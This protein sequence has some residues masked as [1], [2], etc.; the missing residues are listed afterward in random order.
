MLNLS[1]Q[2]ML[3]NANALNPNLIH[4]T[5]SRTLTHKD[6]CYQHGLFY[7]L[8]Y[9]I[10]SCCSLGGSLPP[11]WNHP[12]PHTCMH[13]Q[14]SV[15]PGH[16]AEKIRASVWFIHI[17]SEYIYFSYH[18]GTYPLPTHTETPTHQHCRMHKDSP[19]GTACKIQCISLSFIYVNISCLSCHLLYF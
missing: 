13:D 8:Y 3:R 18:Q 5:P 2:W 17:F 1:K 14:F 16:A 11:S 6:G 19:K 12:A 4:M 15:S 10:A 7:G 9:S